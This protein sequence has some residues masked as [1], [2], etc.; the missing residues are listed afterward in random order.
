MTQEN[1]LLQN[2]LMPGVS[3]MNRIMPGCA[4]MSDTRLDDAIARTRDYLLS[5]QHPEGFW[6]GKL[7]QYIK[8]K[9]LPGGGWAIFPGGPPELSASVKAYF[10]MKLYGISPNEEFMQQSREMIL[11][12]GGVEKCNSFT[13]IYLAMFGQYDWNAVPAIPPEIILF[14]KESYFN[15]Y[16]TL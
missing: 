12:L 13:K 9:M 15:I 8:Q 5:I 6:V 14:P 1:N 3:T 7:I 10:V 11:K 2:T 4:V 16:I